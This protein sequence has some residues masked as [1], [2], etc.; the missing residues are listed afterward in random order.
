MAIASLL[1]YPTN[2]IPCSG[3]DN[4]A[5]FHRLPAPRK[6]VFRRGG[7]ENPDEGDK[8]CLAAAQ[9]LPNT[10]LSQYQLMTM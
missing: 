1:P 2:H 4:A 9:P 7:Q 6:G 3:D 10:I 8:W 5:P